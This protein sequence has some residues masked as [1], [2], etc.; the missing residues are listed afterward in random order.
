MASIAGTAAL[1][2]GAPVLGIG[3]VGWATISIAASG[4]SA[5]RSWTDYRNARISGAEFGMSLGL[6]AASNVPYLG[7]AWGIGNVGWEI[8]ETLFH[9]KTPRTRNWKCK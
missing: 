2:S 1:I 6:S 4:Y 3:A 8:G 7:F 5:Y 9:S